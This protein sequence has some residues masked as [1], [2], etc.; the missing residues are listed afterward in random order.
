MGLTLDLEPFDYLT[1]YKL[2]GTLL[3]ILLGTSEAAKIAAAFRSL[4]FDAGHV[5]SATAHEVV[6]QAAVRLS[7]R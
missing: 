1:L 2:P 5:Y 7:L 3:R 6:Y 4:G